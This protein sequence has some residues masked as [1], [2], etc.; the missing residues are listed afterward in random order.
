M[1]VQRSNPQH[2]GE[3]CKAIM[4]AGDCFVPRNDGG[5]MFGIL[6]RQI[7][8]FRRILFTDLLAPHGIV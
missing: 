8:R 7:S 2:G 3:Q 4:Q 6:S 5:R 1:E